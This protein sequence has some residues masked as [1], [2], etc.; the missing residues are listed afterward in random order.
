MNVFFLSFEVTVRFINYHGDCR[1]SAVCI[2]NNGVYIVWNRY[3]YDMHHI[4]PLDS[5]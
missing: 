5:Q 2:P 1:E 4:F 3:V